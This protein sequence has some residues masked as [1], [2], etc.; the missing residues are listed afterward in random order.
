MTASGDQ[1]PRI[2]RR[3]RFEVL[4][5]DNYSC[6]YCGSRAPEVPLTVDHVKPRA[7]GGTNDPENLV[8]ACGPCNSGKASVAPDSP[9]VADVDMDALRWARAIGYAADAM[10]EEI[11]E[12]GIVVD[13][14]DDAWS[15]WSWSPR[16]TSEPLPR[17]NNWEAS[18]IRLRSLGLSRSIMEDL[19]SV[20]MRKNMGADTWKYFCGCCWR[21]LDKMH[22]VAAGLLATVDGMTMCDQPYDD[23]SEPF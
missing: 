11:R 21:T 5:R 17:D 22:D 16:G 3:L 18:V 10:E 2:P 9:L 12:R 20:S 23:S 1:A 13:Q 6:R 14:F 7:L 15:I 4:R 19:I 8:A